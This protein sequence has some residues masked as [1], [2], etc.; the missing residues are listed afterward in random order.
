MA[1]D[2]EKLDAI[3]RASDVAA[4]IAFFRGASEAERKKVAKVAQN[5]MRELTKRTSIPARLLANLAQAHIEPSMTSPTD[6]YAISHSI[7]D[8]VHVA[9]LASGSLSQWKSLG[10]ESIAPELVYLILNDRRPPWLDQLVE[11]LLEP[12]PPSRVTSCWPQIR[13]MIRDGLCQTP[14][15]TD[16]LEGMLASLHW[17]SWHRKKDLK[18][19]LLEDPGLLDDEIWRIFEC[20]PRAGN[21]QILYIGNADNNANNTWEQA[22]VELT[23]EGRIPRGRLLDATLDGLDRDFHEQRARWFAALHELLGPTTAERAGFASRYLALLA[24]RNAS[25]VG[26]ALDALKI[27]DS[28]E[29]VDP[30]ALVASI[31]PAVQARTKGTIRLALQL[32]ER[33]AHRGAPSVSG[34][35]AAIV[36]ADALVHEAPDIQGAVIDLIERLGDPA[37]PE[38]RALLVDRAGALAPS[39]RK[40]LESWLGPSPGP[41]SGETG[42]LADSEDLIARAAAIEPRW[43]R[44]AGVPAALDALRNGGD[45]PS[46]VFDGTEIPRLDPAR[47][48]LPITGLDELIDLFARVIEDRAPPDDFERVLDGVSR[49]CDQRPDDFAARLAPLTAR[50]RYLFWTEQY[51]YQSSIAKAFCGLALSWS[52]CGLA[53]GCEHPLGGERNMHSIINPN[54]GSLAANRVHHHRREGEMSIHGLIG[55]RVRSISRRAAARQAAPL[56]STPTHAGGW[57][58]P[59]V[60]VE[61]IRQRFGAPFADDEFDIELALLRLAPEHRDS[62]LQAAA[63]LSGKF[64]AALRYALG[65]TED[66]PIGSDASLWAAAAR[67]R[68]PRADDPRVEERFPGLGPDAGLAAR[69]VLRVGQDV[70]PDR[71]ELTAFFVRYKRPAFFVDRK[72][73]VPTDGKHDLP[74]SCLHD[75][76]NL[77]GEIVSWAATIWPMVR[78]PLF[79][80]GAEIVSVNNRGTTDVMFSQP[81]FPP[82]LDPDVPLQPMGMLLLVTGLNAARRELSGLATDALI[83]AINDGRIDGDNLGETLAELARIK[84]E[85]PYGAPAWNTPATK[86][87]PIP[88]VKLSRWA[89][90][91]GD[92]ARTS[93][94]HARVISKAIARMLRGESFDARTT[95]SRNTLLVLLKELLI[96]TGEALSDPD[97]RAYLNQD[98]TS[99]KKGSL[100]HE[101]LNL[102][103]VPDHPTRHATA[104]QALAR[105]VERAERWAA[106]SHDM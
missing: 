10:L 13:R 21:I 61:R 71:Y 98:K 92:A 36:A 27:L 80:T 101:L 16:Y 54:D 58:D 46:L 48:L 19:L 68:D 87:L 12:T 25:T 47:K 41:S 1:L 29:Q 69:Y 57:I 35:Q 106:W 100:I 62:A 97:A 66:E 81:F 82:L 43:A 17:E 78:E 95:T 4:C 9:A 67:A 53:L 96:E 63:G 99:G 79:A 22:L 72:P 18:A 74:M 65:F 60:L 49:L 20:E 76:R 40:R 3:I 103:A 39:Q 52:T 84:I 90:A 59:R 94:L 50:A 89:K 83:A 42:P 91:L 86:A 33:A 31:A 6:S 24:S 93:P 104:V 77:V 45:V 51:F 85:P 73:G 88:F 14:M 70:P 105:R 30:V 11:V 23:R 7:F 64:G 37:N 5:H 56:L 28:A 8:A 55:R 2:A 75:H 15:S 102:K 34:S 38:L 32:L 26:F 44:L